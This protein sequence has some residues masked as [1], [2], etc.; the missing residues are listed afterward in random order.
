MEDDTRHLARPTAE[1]VILV[2]VHRQSISSATKVSS[3]HILVIESPWKK[4]ADLHG[5]IRVYRGVS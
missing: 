1:L 5:P 4:I 3:D 2:F